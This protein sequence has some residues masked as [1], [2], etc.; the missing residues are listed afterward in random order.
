MK[1][2]FL[3][4]L[5]G[6]ALAGQSG[7]GGYVGGPGDVEL[8]SALA[9]QWGDVAA[10]RPENLPTSTPRAEAQPV[11]NAAEAARSSYL[12][13]KE[14]LYRSQAARLNALASKLESAA[15]RATRELAVVEEL[16]ARVRAASNALRDLSAKQDKQSLAESAALRS[17][18][19]KLEQLLRTTERSAQMQKESE[20]DEIQAEIMRQ[21]AIAALRTDAASFQSLAESST[22][23]RLAWHQFYLHLIDR[24]CGEEEPCRERR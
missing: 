12:R 5:V 1:A 11:I 19:E 21:K 20:N 18:K 6:I 7:S 23:E 3:S 22:G 16:K 14:S 13:T 15:P 4:F 2:S 17:L 8:W 10:L 24:F 9:K